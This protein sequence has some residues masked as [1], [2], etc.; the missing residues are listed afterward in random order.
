MKTKAK[1]DD[2]R[3]PALGGALAGDAGDTARE[4]KSRGNGDEEAAAEV[5]A[6][7]ERRSIRQDLLSTL[8]TAIFQGKI[9]AGKTL[10]IQRLAAKF[11][12]S[13]T[14]IREALVQLATIGMV[15]MRHNYGT[16]ARKFG[17][18]ELREIYHLRSLLESEASRG[19][20]G[21]IPRGELEQLQ[22]E[23]EGLLKV[24]GTD[25][26]ERAMAAD[27]ALHAMIARNCGSRRL[28]EEIGRYELLMQCIRDVVGN[29]CHA[30]DKG[31]REHLNIVDALLANHPELAAQAM[32]AHVLSTAESV[33]A[34]RFNG[35]QP[36]APGSSAVP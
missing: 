13:A 34:A 17:P 33:K 6:P 5:V 23:L 3:S 21:R 19:A 25:W 14:P 36:I 16:V 4:K 32:Q 27:R 18:V 22:A 15:E 26:S 28:E 2:V 35:D 29:F 11:G 30:Q 31:L 7:L 9:E 8:L 24:R 20:C 10:N 1:R 12:V